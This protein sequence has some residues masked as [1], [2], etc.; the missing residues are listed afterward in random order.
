[1][2]P[3]YSLIAGD[4]G[5]GELLPLRPEV[6]HGIAHKGSP[7][8]CEC[9]HD[10]AGSGKDVEGESVRGYRYDPEEGEDEGELDEVCCDEVEEFADEDGLVLP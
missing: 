4:G 1:M 10:K 8:E 9:C 3:C 6:A 2:R 5:A 7:E